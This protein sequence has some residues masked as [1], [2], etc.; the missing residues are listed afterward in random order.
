L[1]KFCNVVGRPVNKGLGMYKCLAQNGTL[2]G[3]AAA[4]V[5]PS[6]L[7]QNSVA[8]PRQCLFGLML[9]TVPVPRKPLGCVVKGVEASVGAS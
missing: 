9:L 1:G 3:L 7:L 4:L 5:L 2:K 6:A 8:I